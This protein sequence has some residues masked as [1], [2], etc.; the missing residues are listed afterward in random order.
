MTD[1]SNK[2][3]EMGTTVKKITQKDFEE[4]R[5]KGLRYG[6]D[7]K[8][9]RGHVCKRKQLFMIEVEEEDEAFEEAQQELPSEETQENFRFLSMHY[10]GYIPTGQ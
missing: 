9:F 5:A 1:S 6:C 3:L 10:Q 2:N 8:Y 4:K 7:E